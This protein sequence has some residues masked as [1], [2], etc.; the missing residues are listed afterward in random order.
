MT[1]LFAI[2]SLS[3]E[4]KM[5]Q[6]IHIGLIKGLKSGSYEDFNALY[7]IYAD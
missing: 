3:N 2:L 7:N 6:N 1:Y 5:N 4:I